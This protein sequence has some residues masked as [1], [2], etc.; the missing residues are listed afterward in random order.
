MNAITIILRLIHIF[1]GVFWVGSSLTLV[2][3]VEP[4]ARAIGPEGAK[5]MQRLTGQTRFTFFAAL[6][7]PLTVL[8]GLVLYWQD[9]G[10][11]PEW[12]LTPSGLGFTVG[13]LAGIA[14]FV[15]GAA[16]IG[17]TAG[18]IAALG[19]E[20]QAAGG[21]PTPAQATK[22]HTLQ[23]KLHRIGVWG[24]ALLALAVVAMATARYL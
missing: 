1:A 19:K 23:E 9:S 6:S 15:L 11:R 14:A 22:M 18:Q 13:G 20:I 24:A 7:A 4:A 8:A 16:I 10:F 5:F 17:P 21:P 2:G 3:F 12:I